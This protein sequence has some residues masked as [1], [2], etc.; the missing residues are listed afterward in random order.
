MLFICYEGIDRFKFNRKEYSN[1]IKQ[2]ISYEN[3]IIGRITLVFCSDQ[4]MLEMNNN[5]LKHDYYTDILTFDYSEND[6]ISGDL[7]LGIGQIT[8]NA[9]EYNQSF[10]VELARVIFHGVLHLVGYK[11]ETSVERRI[12]SEK[13]NKYLKKFKLIK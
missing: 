10:S 1:W 9:E 6:N 12:M 8:K 11:D 13:E 2:L 5:F 4:Y 3:K 7:L